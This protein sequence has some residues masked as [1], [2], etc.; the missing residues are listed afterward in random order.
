MNMNRRDLLKRGA[1]G[2]VGLV[3]L[4]SLAQLLSTMDAYAAPD[5]AS[6][7]MTALIAAAKKE[8]H[9]N[10]IALPPDWADYGEIMKTF[11]S[12]YGI[13]ITNTNPDG[14]SAQEVQAVQS[15]K[16]QGRAP[17]VVDV[18]PQFA[19]QGKQLGI[20]APYKVA[21]WASIPANMKDPDGYW[22]GDYWGVESFLTNTSVI[23]E[24]PK[25]WADLL[26]PKLK[27]AVALDN[28][29]RAASDAF[30][31][32]F[33]AAL[34]N[35]G[36]LDNIEPGIDFFVKVKKAG[37]WNPTIAHTAQ[38]AKGA[39]PVVIKWDYLNLAVRDE[40]NGNPTVEITIPATGKYGGYYCQAINKYAPNPNA[41]KLWQ[42]YIYSDEG[43]LMYLKGYTHPA[44]YQDLAKRHKI[45]AALAAKLPAAE[46]Y[47]GVQFASLAQIAKATKVLAEQWGPKMIGS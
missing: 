10:T 22:Y 42:E 41:A 21:T 36:S 43:Q 25:D 7:G 15:L 31:A 28:D 1:A 26:S 20:Y 5:G 44:R 11:Q 40:L 13:S 8:G 16:G 29:P 34:G 45:P 2:A 4:P 30:S 9:L 32:V 19:L 3:G 39:T 46:E 27:G 35:G 23:K 47:K 38:I 17:D 6:G 37:N 33:A 18:G 24:A 14:S 12:K